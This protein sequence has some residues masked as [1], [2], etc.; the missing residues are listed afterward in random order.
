[1]LA[2]EVIVEIAGAVVEPAVEPTVVLVLEPG[3]SFTIR[4]SSGT[5]GTGKTGLTL[6]LSN[7]CDTGKV[8][9]VF[10][11]LTEE[12]YNLMVMNKAKR[13]KKLASKS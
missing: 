3:Q 10:G 2:E 13:A 11:N 9:D 12:D 8:T 4:D 6:R 1:M 5:I 7:Y